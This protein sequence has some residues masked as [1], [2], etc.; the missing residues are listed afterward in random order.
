MFWFFRRRPAR[1]AKHVW[2]PAVDFR[3]ARVIATLLTFSA[4]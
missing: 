3:D 2:T 4:H 1:P